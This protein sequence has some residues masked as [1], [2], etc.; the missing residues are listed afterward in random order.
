MAR[1]VV[2]VDASPGAGGSDDPPESLG[3][4]GYA[5][6]LAGFIER[7]G[8]ERTNVA[9]LSFGG[10]L[11]LELC[12]RLPGRLVLV[13]AY[14]GWGLAARRGRRP[15]PTPGLHPGR[16]IG[17]DL[18]TRRSRL[19]A[20]RP[21]D[22]GHVCNIEVNASGLGRRGLGGHEPQQRA[23]EGHREAVL[24]VRRSRPPGR[25][26]DGRTPAPSA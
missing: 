3:L 25:E 9:G 12:R 26:P 22:A 16:P 24:A 17:E 20:G 4:A 19:Q 21:A 14:A 2:G 10:I 18:S 13:S 1:I 6:C 5:D 7:L 23:G 15:A 11:A 8:L